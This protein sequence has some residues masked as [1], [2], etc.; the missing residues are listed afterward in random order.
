MVAAVSS[1]LPYSAYGKNFLYAAGS[2]TPLERYFNSNYAAYFMRRRMLMPEWM[3]PA[4][5]AFLQ[6]MLPDCFAPDGGDIMSQMRYFEATA[7]L[8][9]DMLVKVD[10]ASMAASLEVRCPMLDHR[11]AEFATRIPNTWKWS[12]RKG[13]RILLGALG[14]RLPPQ[15]LLGKKFLERGIVSPEFMRYLVQEHESGRRSNEDQLYALLM[16]E[17]WFESL[18]EPVG[19]PN[20]SSCVSAN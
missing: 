13:K 6:R 3:L 18:Q 20:L 12:D 14:D 19:D 10:R 5:A 4:D 2:R 7:N 17:L 11:F 1:A 8:T 9:G 16:L 15:L